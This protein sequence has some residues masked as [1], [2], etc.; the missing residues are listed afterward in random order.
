MK[1]GV[2][3]ICTTILQERAFFTS[4]RRFGADSEKRGESSIVVVVGGGDKDITLS[5]VVCSSL[6]LYG[7]MD[8]REEWKLHRTQDE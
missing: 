3:G 5:S 8:M 7:W 6:S 4:Q 1:A 2:G